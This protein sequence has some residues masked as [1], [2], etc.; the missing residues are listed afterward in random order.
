M[1]DDESRNSCTTP[2]QVAQERQRKQQEKQRQEAEASKK[3]RKPGQKRRGLGGLSKEKKRMLKQLIMQKAAEIMKAERKKEQEKRDEYVRSKIGT[4]NLEGLSENEL[5][6]KVSQLHEQLRQLEGEKYDWEEKLR[7]QDVE[8][9]TECGFLSLVVSPSYGISSMYQIIIDLEQ[10]ILSYHQNKIVYI[11][12][13]NH[14]SPPLKC[15]SHHLFSV[16]DCKCLVG[17]RRSFIHPSS[18]FL[19]LYSVKPVL[20]KVSKTESHMAR[21]EKKE[22]GHSLSSFRNQLKSTGHSKYALEEK[23]ETGGKADWRDQLKPK[24]EESAAPAQ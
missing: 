2:L 22:T 1:S 6:S 19:L 18:L 15:M 13:C 10:I 5:R 24:E 14:Q 8:V 23:D 21:F 3:Q 9:R 16:L 12:M 17:F 11:S 4:L 20:K 7:R